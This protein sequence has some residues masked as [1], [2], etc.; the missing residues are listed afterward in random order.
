MN[1]KG[2]G[3]VCSCPQSTTSK[4]LAESMW[5]QREQREM[6]TIGKATE[7]AREAYE[8]LPNNNEVKRASKCN[9]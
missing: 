2:H 5:Q 3:R 8:G 6:K 9:K 1:I 7:A 4:S